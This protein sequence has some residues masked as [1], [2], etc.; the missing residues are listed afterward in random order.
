MRTTAE[1]RV[2]PE[3]FPRAFRNLFLARRKDVGIETD[4][5]EQANGQRKTMAGQGHR[6]CRRLA[7]ILPVLSRR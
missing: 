2:N 5:Q 4:C 3:N 7:K 6:G 1:G